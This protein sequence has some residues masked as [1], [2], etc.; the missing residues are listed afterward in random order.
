M[1]NLKLYTEESGYQMKDILKCTVFLADMS[2]W[3]AF[4]DVYGSYFKKPFPA[5][6][7]V[8]VKSL[9]LDARVEIEC[10]ASR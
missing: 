7:A 2:E 5:R 3:S 8:A 4:N 9:A 1:D 6:T 10:I